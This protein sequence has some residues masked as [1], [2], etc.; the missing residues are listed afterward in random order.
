MIMGQYAR[1]CG[2]IKFVT[3]DFAVLLVCMRVRASVR[4]SDREHLDSSADQGRVH[5][6]ACYR[7]LGCGEVGSACQRLAA[8]EGGA[9]RVHKRTV[10]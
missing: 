2:R 7:R 3:F 6:N 5:P 4:L 10:H 8:S 1:L 9:D